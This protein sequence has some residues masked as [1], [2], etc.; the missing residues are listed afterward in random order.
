MR[1]FFPGSTLETNNRKAGIILVTEAKP[2]IIQHK[3]FI[4]RVLEIRVRL[5]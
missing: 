5:L 1:H 3:N 2:R 4:N